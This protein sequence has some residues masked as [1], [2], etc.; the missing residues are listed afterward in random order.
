MES[1]GSS[2]LSRF[3]FSLPRRLFLFLLIAG[4]GRGEEPSGEKVLRL[5][6]IQIG[7]NGAKF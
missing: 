5:R 3:F 7:F 6:V 2:F 1:Y 4:P